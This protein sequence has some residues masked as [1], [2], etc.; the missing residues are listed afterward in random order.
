[1]AELLLNLR[2]VPDD[3]ADEIRALLAAHEIAF[4]ETPPSR[5][6]VSAGGIWVRDRGQAAAAGR[7][8]A[9]YHAR[10]QAAAQAEYRAARE[11]GAA[12][13][14]WTSIRDDPLR[15]LAAMLGIAFV[16]AFVIAILAL[17]FVLLAR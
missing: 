17:P 11:A 1:M 10:R 16:V 15:A 7:L 14:L 8:L 4:Y 6:G 2:G 13:T 9:E 3:E 5:F 12:R